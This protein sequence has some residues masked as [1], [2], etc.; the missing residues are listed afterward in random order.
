MYGHLRCV[1]KVLAN[2]AQ[3][4]LA[5]TIHVYGV[6]TV[7]LAGKSSSIRSYM[8]YIHSSGQRCTVRVGQ[9]H[10]YIRCIHG[11]FGREITNRTDIYG[12]YTQLWPNLHSRK[13]E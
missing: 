8:V 4:G 2:P 3:L 11:V 7:F 6:Y 5:R 10:K 1:H 12:V 9:N 13:H